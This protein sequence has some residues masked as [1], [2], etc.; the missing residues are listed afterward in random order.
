MIQKDDPRI[1]AVGSLDEL[2]STIGLALCFVQ[3]EELRKKLVKIQ[4]DLFTVGADLAG[5]AL[6]LE[7]TPRITDAHIT[8]VEEIIDI[9][10]EKLGMPKKFILPG[11]TLTSSLLHLCRS[12]AR[13]AERNLVQA[14]GKVNLNPALLRYVN[15]LSDFLY[16]LARDANHE[17]SLQEQ[18]PLYKYIKDGDC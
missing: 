2:N 9:L 17:E 8:E 16:V 7:K 12:V 14:S 18:H 15:R 11:G 6:P 4:N 3:K 10:E 5:S 1:E 13:R